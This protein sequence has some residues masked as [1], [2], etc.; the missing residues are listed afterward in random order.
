[1]FSVKSRYIVLGPNISDQD[2]MRV[3]TGEKPFKCTVCNKGFN[4]KT[5]PYMGPERLMS[6]SIIARTSPTKLMGVQIIM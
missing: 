5:K 1:M 4:Q 2:D 6:E 3:H